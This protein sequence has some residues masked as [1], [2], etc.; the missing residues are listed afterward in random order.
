MV[1]V[2][3]DANVIISAAIQPSGPPG[4]IC[5]AFLSRRAF[6]LVLSPVIVEEVERVLSLN[7]VRKRLQDPNGAQAL[8]FDL[9]I[10]SDVVVDTSRVRGVCRDPA[11]D[12]V[13][14]TAVEGRAAV[15][16]TGDDDLLSL[17]EYEDIVIMAPKAF[18]DL[19]ER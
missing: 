7:K 13:L 10:F 8:L 1:R 3:L 15:I 2:V 11:D 18:A 5:A 6:E 14:A 9:V 19:L 17:V 12:A 16:V 4:R